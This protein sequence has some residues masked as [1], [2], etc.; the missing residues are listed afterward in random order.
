MSI[1][2]EVEFEK[3][4]VMAQ[5]LHGIMIH[6]DDDLDKPTVLRVLS[7]MLGDKDALD[8]QEQDAAT[9]ILRKLAKRL[10]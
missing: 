4:V 9:A 10:N 3:C 2:K 8:Q 6:I 5:Q 1:E 7:S